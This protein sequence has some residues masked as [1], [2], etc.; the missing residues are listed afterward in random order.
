MQPT[1]LARIPSDNPQTPMP[2]D[3]AQVSLRDQLLQ[4]TDWLDPNLSR[5]ARVGLRLIFPL[6]FGAISYKNGNGLGHS[7]FCILA[8]SYALY[9]SA[10]ACGSERVAIT[11]MGIGAFI[12]M[13]MLLMQG[14]SIG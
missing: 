3:A 6:C 11:M 10:Q 4:A 13:V 8:T 14:G 7:L 2:A 9:Q 12:G 1:S 5:S